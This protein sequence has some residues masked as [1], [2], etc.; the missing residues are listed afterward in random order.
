MSDMAHCIT[1]LIDLTLG[2]H[3]Q[4]LS[5]RRGVCKKWHL[6]YKTNDISETKHGRS[7]EPTLLQSVY[8]NR[9]RSIDWWQI[10][11]RRPNFGLLFRGAKFFH[12]GHLTHFLSERNE[13]WPPYGSRQSKLIPRIS[14][15]VVGYRG[16]VIPC[17]DMHQSFADTLVKWFFDSLRVAGGL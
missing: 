5:E 7:L 4:I 1:L 16:P 8:K 11:W 14:W 9:V 2:E 10:W 15:T 13:I 6:R 3:L 17:G 12:N